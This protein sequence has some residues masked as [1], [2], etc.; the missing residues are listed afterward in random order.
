[1]PGSSYCPTPTTIAQRSGSGRGAGGGGGGRGGGAPGAV[2]DDG[3]DLLTDGAVRI[4]GT[5]HDRVGP[6][7]DDQR[8]GDGEGPLGGALGLLVD[9]RPVEDDRDPGD[10]AAGGE[11]RGEDGV[12]VGEPGL[13]LR[14]ADGEGEGGECS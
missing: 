2:E 7:L 11:D 13:V 1:M 3:A 4:A 9:L 14:I 6:G 10:A 5:E 12:L 8:H